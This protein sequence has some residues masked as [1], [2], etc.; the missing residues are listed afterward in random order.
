MN[1]QKLGKNLRILG[2]FCILIAILWFA[3][4]TGVSDEIDNLNCLF[5]KCFSGFG[6]VSSYDPKVMWVGIFSFIVGIIIKY[7]R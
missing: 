7:S 3:L 2:L 5:E 4:S 6:K 1:I